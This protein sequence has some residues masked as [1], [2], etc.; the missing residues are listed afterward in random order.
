MS[1][2]SL[3][4]LEIDMLDISKAINVLEKTRDFVDIIE[5]GSTLI[6][7]EGI[8]LLRILRSKFEDIPILVDIRTIDEGEYDTKPF[9]ENGAS[10]LTVLG[11]SDNKTIE[12]A[13]KVANQYK[14]KIVVD[15]MAVKDKV[16]RIAELKTLGAD[17]FYIHN[18]FDHNDAPKSYIA[19]FKDVANHFPDLK[20]FVS[21]STNAKDIQDILSLSPDVIVIGNDITNASD[22][23]GMA[24]SVK[25]IVTS[26]NEKNSI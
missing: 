13:I 15:L 19:E 16:A 5:I 8:N 10:Y 1:K 18:A 12:G 23:R 4:Q 2:K 14:G 26:F 22:P 20:L 25:E 24:K 11:E 9:F 3:L 6:K 21:G 17:L 7:C